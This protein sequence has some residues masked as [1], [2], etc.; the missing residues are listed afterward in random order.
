MSLIGLGGYQC[1]AR[2]SRKQ[3]KNQTKECNS[4]LQATACQ[5]DTC[6]PT[7][8][9]STICHPTAYQPTACQIITSQTYAS[10]TYLS[11][12]KKFYTAIYARLSIADSGKD[13]KESIGIQIDLLRYYVNS[14]PYL[15]LDS[16]YCDN[17]FSGTNFERPEWNRLI[18]DVKAGKINCILVKDLSRLGRDYI[19]TGHYL[20]HIFPLLGVRFIAIN[21]NYDSE[22]P[23]C[24]KESFRISLKNLVN[25]FY[26]K[27]IS[28]KV[29]TSS[30]LKQKKGEY[31][32]A[33]PP[34]GYLFSEEGTH[35]L[36]ID[37]GVAPVV[38][39]IFQWCIVGYSDSEIAN[40]LN[41]R[42]VS[43]PRTHYY[44][45]GLIHSDR[46]AVNKK[47]QNSTI[48]RITENKVYLGC[49]VRGK[50][51]ESLYDNIKRHDTH[52]SEWIIVLNTQEAIIHE[53][54]FQ[55]VQSIRNERKSKCIGNKVC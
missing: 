6:Q 28:K 16:V 52:E 17:G 20:D 1:M 35:K 18:E 25:N 50:S 19:E 30:Y 49:M 11:P 22:D 40:M 12:Q 2:T 31:Q 10:P 53:E 44:E 32:G 7:I 55:T 34:Y 42:G 48:K 15:H 54:V 47:W 33:H 41:N 45:L 5:T 9:Q 29:S 13:N 46:Y 8:C 37:K 23:N 39:L 14:R 21:D 43:T 27:D 24:Y 3:L 4:V 51:K 36:V 38:K 26:A